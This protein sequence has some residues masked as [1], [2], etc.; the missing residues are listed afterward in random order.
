LLGPKTDQDTNQPKEP[1]EKK[2]HILSHICDRKN[3]KELL[4]IN[5]FQ[6]LILERRN[7]QGSLS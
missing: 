2:V 5:F 6:K 3:L 4:K 7:C 1:K